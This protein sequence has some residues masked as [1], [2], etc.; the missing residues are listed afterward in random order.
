M[1]TLIFDIGKTN[2]KVFV[3]DADYQIIY[4]ESHR[5][6]EIK[7]EDGDACDDLDS[8]IEWITSTTKKNT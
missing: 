2:K 4:E 6:S 3:F 1:Q 7:D 8:L 5:I